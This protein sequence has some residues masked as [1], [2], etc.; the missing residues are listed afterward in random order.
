MIPLTHDRPVTVR[1]AMPED[2]PEVHRMSIALAGLQGAAAAMTRPLLDD[3]AAGRAARL[4]VALRPDSPQR[5]PVGYLLLLVGQNMIAGAGWG[6]VEQLYVQDP[7]RGRGI[8]KAL[9]TAAREVAARAGCDG[10]TVQSRAETDSRAL[11]FRAARP[12]DAPLPEPCLG[13]G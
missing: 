5:H 4:L 10:L 11:A 3:I 1:L 12:L 9:V 6:F 7:D 8:G 2:L 13:V